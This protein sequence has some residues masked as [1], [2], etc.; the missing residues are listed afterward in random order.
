MGKRTIRIPRSKIEAQLMEL[1][2]KAA[3]IVM[4]DGT[5]HAGQIKS[6]E[7]SV[8]VIADANAAWTSESRHAQKLA[9]A[10]IQ[11]IILDVISP[12]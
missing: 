6:A 9:I 11:F 2:G 4:L 7:K 1:P 5:T 10:D 8:L 3:Q 12:W